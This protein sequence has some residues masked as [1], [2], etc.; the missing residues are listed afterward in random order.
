MKLLRPTESNLGNL[1]DKSI[2]LLWFQNGFIRLGVWDKTSYCF[3]DL[4]TIQ[5]NG[6]GM[7]FDQEISH[8]MIVPDLTML[9]I[10]E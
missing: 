10:I 2:C 9:D 5:S 8:I 1:P 4:N 6:V 3:K 7:V